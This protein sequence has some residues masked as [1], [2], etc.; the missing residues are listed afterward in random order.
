MAELANRYSVSPLGGLDV[1]TKLE[2]I[3]AGGKQQ[4]RIK[5]WQ[6]TAPDIIK[7]GNP[8]EIAELMIKYPEMQQQIGSIAGYKQKQLDEDLVNTARDIL[9]NGA[10]PKQALGQHV[11]KAQQAQEDPTKPLTTLGK[12]IQNPMHGQQ[13]AEKVLALHDPAGYQNYKKATTAAMPDMT[14]DQKEYFQA[15]QQGFTGSLLEWKMTTGGKEKTE[16]IKEY[17]YGLNNPNFMLRK[18][19]KEQ[20]ALTKAT[21]KQSFSDSNDLR[22]EYLKQSGDFI[23]VRDA[24]TRVVQSTQDPSPAGDL[25]LIFNY[26][27][28]L[29][30]GSVVRE[31]EF[32]TAAAAGSYGDRIQA[33]VQK[34]M[35]GERLNPNMRKDFL[36]KSSA[37]LTG[38]EKQHDKRKKSYTDIATRNQLP[39]EDVVVDIGKI[40]TT[41][42]SVPQY[43][44]GQTATG[45]AG[46]KMIF[47]NGEWRQM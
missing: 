10:D 1:G 29:D 36:S 16:A 47:T 40:D 15:Q 26:M 23:K 20:D 6:E 7:G 31:S 46:Q 21:S 38:M 12:T 11:Q 39:V 30:P 2:N 42:S 5:Q 45:P 27:K 35:S 9:I 19:Q 37:L 24:Y 22:K 18:K 41:D 8:D 43:E 17:E 14:A 25:A 13:W 34:V 44:E 28:M 3:I 4:Y 32:A 33:S